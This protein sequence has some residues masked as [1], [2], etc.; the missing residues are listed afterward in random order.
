M[1]H[2]PTPPTE[3]VS[4]ALV[5]QHPERGLNWDAPGIPTESLAEECAEVESFCAKWTRSGITQQREPADTVTIWSQNVR[6]LEGTARVPWLKTMA[7]LGVGILLIQDHQLKQGS[8]KDI[9]IWAPKFFGE[10][11]SRWISS[12]LTAK[13]TPGGG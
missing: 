13:D 4:A 11:R 1:I 3:Q 2:T 8:K 6:S 7:K 10:I 12:L 5:V 9:E